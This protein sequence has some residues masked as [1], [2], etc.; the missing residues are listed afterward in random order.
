MSVIDSRQDREAAVARIADQDDAALE[1]DLVHW[2]LASVDSA[3]RYLETNE[4][5]GE[6]RDLHAEEQTW[7][8]LIAEELGK[9]RLARRTLA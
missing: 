4:R 5:L 6:L 9:R 3:K 7:V 8:N 1:R 2:T